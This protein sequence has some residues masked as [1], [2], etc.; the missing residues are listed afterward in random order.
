MKYLLLK[1]FR[2]FRT[3]VFLNISVFFIAFFGV[4]F[5][6]GLSAVGNNIQ[7]GID[8]FYDKHALA[9]YTV[10]NKISLSE[11]SAIRDELCADGAA[12]MDAVTLKV[13]GVNRNA[14][15]SLF[16]SKDHRVNIPEIVSGTMPE[17]SFEALIDVGFAETNGVKTGDKFTIKIEREPYE[18]TI[19]GLARFPDHL[20]KGD[21]IPRI[22]E[23]CVLKVYVDL[24]IKVDTLYIVTE[25]DEQG[26]RDKLCAITDKNSFADAQIFG[27]DENVSVVRVRT[28]IQL[29][30]SLIAI[31]PAICLIALC[32]IL[33]VN[34]SKRIEDESYT[35]GVMSANGMGKMSIAVAYCLPYLIW[36][37]IGGLLGAIVGVSVMPGVYI[38]VLEKFYTLPTLPSTGTFGA[39]FLPL[40][41]LGA[42][43][44]FALI[45]A[46][47]GVMMCTPTQLM[48]GRTKKSVKILNKVRLPLTLKLSLRNFL[49]YKKKSFFTILSAMLCL[50]LLF[51]SFLLDNSVDNLQETVYGKYYNYDTTISWNLGDGL[52]YNAVC[53]DIL[54]TECF[55]G[56]KYCVEFPATVMVGEQ[57]SVI[58]SIIDEEDPCYDLYDGNGKIEFSNDGVYIPASYG[59]MESI[60]LKA[61]GIDPKPLE[62]PVVGSFTDMGLF[63]VIFTRGFIQNNV[64]FMNFFMT[65]GAEFAEL[66][67]TVYTVRSDDVTEEQARN[68]V[69]GL[70]EKYSAAFMYQQHSVTSDRFKQL[71]KVLDITELI[72]FVV[73]GIMMILLI[74]NISCLSISDRIKD[75]T[76]FKAMGVGAKRINFLNSLENYCSIIIAFILSLPLGMLISSEIIKG[77][78]F[79]TGVAVYLHVYTISIVILACGAALNAAVGNIFINRKISKVNIV[80][81]LKIKE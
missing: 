15:V 27:R 42:V 58:V 2:D 38:G 13:N 3:S 51:T 66:S 80:D 46:I 55:D 23:T 81:S 34:M 57:K 41:I 56:I 1:Q 68:S 26:I 44:V 29:I 64:D 53:E 7:S 4:L 79:I 35:I 67:T 48:R 30:N 25:L 20:Y 70:E 36:I 39:I 62:L 63:G 54:A 5:F 10:S 40:L 78:T 28:D 6:S 22:E 8:D 74:I 49:S 65:H 9:V 31:L 73:C 24:D 43:T 71:F 21:S 32:L 69:K 37:L 14:L 77:V 19:V 52:D 45:V 12:E 59:K 11:L 16:P 76:I 60:T 72:L 18:I 61:Y 33:Y 17:N 50:S 75:Y 47:I